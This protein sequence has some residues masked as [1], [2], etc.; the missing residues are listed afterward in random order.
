MAQHSATTA[1]NSIVSLAVRF[2]STPKKYAGTVDNQPWDDESSNLDCRHGSLKNQVE[3]ILE[4]TCD[5]SGVLHRRLSAGR[6]QA[7]R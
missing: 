7:A 3:T 4:V 2:D 1:A 6:I 5:S